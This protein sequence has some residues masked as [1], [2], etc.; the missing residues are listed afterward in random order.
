ME[1]TKLNNSIPLFLPK[2]EFEY[3]SQV[4]Q[5]IADHWMQEIVM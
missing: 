4:M 5:Q 2:I 1:I 3:L